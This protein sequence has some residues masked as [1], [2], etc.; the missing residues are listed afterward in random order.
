MGKAK[1][2]DKKAGA[3]DGGK[4]KGKAD[5]EDKSDSKVKGAQSINVRHI[6]VCGRRSRQL[7]VSLTALGVV[8]EARQ[9]GR[10]SREAQGRRQV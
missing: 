8:R 1:T 2:D 6:L 10:S 7:A 5:K 9:K 4:G 3:K